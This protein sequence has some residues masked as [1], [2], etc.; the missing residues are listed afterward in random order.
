MQLVVKETSDGLQYL[1][2]HDENGPVKETS[3]GLQY[4]EFHDE[5]LVKMLIENKQLREQLTSGP[6]ESLKQELQ[7]VRDR[8]K[9]LWKGM[10]VSKFESLT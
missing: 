9:E 6:I 2:F 5:K 7:Q 1:K 10:F 4:L 8:V 3:D